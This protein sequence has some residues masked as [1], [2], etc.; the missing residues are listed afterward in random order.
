MVLITWMDITQGPT[1]WSDLD[2]ALADADSA[3]G[4][5]QQLGFLLDKTEDHIVLLDS[6]FQTNDVVGTYTK[7]PRSVVKSVTYLK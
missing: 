1:G 2:D 3:D 7:I 4:M 6:Y 5:V